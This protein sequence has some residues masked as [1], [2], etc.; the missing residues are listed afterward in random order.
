MENIHLIDF[1]W[2]D[3]VDILIVSIVLYRIFLLIKGTRAVQMLWGLFLISGAYTVS[4]FFDFFTIQWIV[5][6]F[7]SFIILII[8]ILFQEDIRRGLT[9]FGRNPFFAGVSQLEETY[10]LEELVKAANTLAQRRIGALIALERESLL[11]E[12]VEMGV[13]IDSKVSRELICSIF[14]P[15]SPLH[16]GALLVRQGRLSAAGCF[17]PLTTKPGIEKNLGTRHR[18]AIGLSERTD[19]AVIVVS[20]EDGTVSLAVNGHIV[21]PVDADTLRERLLTMFNPR[22][23][24]SKGSRGAARD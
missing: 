1:N 20:E 10:V 5:N 21:K 7:L 8:V 4:R 16:D 6:N 24:P 12:F 17:L 11:N 19:A 2:H 13:S 3:V 14:L 22:K 23:T 18:A 15:Y 9:R